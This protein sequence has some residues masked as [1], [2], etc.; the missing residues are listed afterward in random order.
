MRVTFLLCITLVLGACG[1]PDRLVQLEV[2]K[3][4]KARDSALCEAL[5]VPVDDLA[6]AIVT[7]QKETPDEVIIKGTTVIRGYDAGC[8]GG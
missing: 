4:L 1:V 5:E 8:V 2:A 6:G 3:A 7:N